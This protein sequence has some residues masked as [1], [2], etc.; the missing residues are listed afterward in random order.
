MVEAGDTIQVKR[1]GV[2]FVLGAVNRP[3]GYVMQEN[4]TLS[5][6]Q[7]IAVAAGTNNIASTK[8]ISLLRRHEDGSVV[9]IELP[10]RK[11][12]RGEMMDVQLR[13]SDILFVP[14]NNIKATFVSSQGI[15]AAAT[16]ASIYAA[17]IY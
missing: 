7:A 14:T 15:I 6:L 16:S 10:Y 11:I 13:P 9:Q 5:V 1:A 2:I 8:S 4:G 17:A 3:G 12:S